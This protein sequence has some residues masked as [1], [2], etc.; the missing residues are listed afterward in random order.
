MEYRDNRR[1]TRRVVA[2]VAAALVL[3]GGSALAQK[4]TVY[5]W[6]DEDGNVHYTESLP[7]ERGDAGHDVLN[8]QGLV[9]DENQRLTPQKTE[10]QKSEEEIKA[11]EAAELPRDSS[12]LPRPKPLYTEAEKQQRMDNFLMLR[13]ES[14]QEITD[15]MDVEIK[16]LN[17]DRRL[18]E[19]S[20]ASI[21]EAWR[22]EIHEAA[23]RQ[24][25]G[26]SVDDGVQKKITRLQ[27]ELAQNNRE[28]DAL[29]AREEKIRADFQAQLERYRF[30]L[31]KYAEEES[32]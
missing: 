14:E 24:R 16:Q 1:M 27:S 18:I 15:A 25:A 8:D 21:M 7:P 12:G 22:G 17:Y 4:K 20:Q 2:T 19:G 10:D 28:L 23:N 3:L 9:I 11:E 31:E 30:L 26:Q 6:V 29:T 13:Y 5:R 32:S